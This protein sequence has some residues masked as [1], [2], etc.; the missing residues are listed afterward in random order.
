MIASAFGY[1]TLRAAEVCVETRCFIIV[2]MIELLRSR[3]I[4]DHILNVAALIFGEARTSDI[5]LQIRVLD[6]K[7]CLC[8][9]T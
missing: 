2:S 4:I 8:T 5:S 9:A 3:M 1:T 6:K 7:L